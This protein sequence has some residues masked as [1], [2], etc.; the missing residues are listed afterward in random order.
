MIKSISKLIGATES[1]T[2]EW[3]PSLSQINEIIE[4]ITAFSNTDGGRVF[5]GVS[6]DGKIIGISIGKDTIENLTN[7]IAQHTEPKIHPHV[8]VTKIDSKE[9]IIINV[10]ESHDKLVLANGKPYI[11]V[12]KSTRQ[13]SKDDYENR[14][15][16]KHKD[17][18]QFDTQ[19]C[20]GAKLKD[21]DSNKV[22]WFMKKALEE[23]RLTIPEKV[24]TK[25]A[26]EYL[27][28]LHSGKPNN[29][30]ILL[31]GKDPQKFFVQAK[32]RAGRIKG[33]EGHDFLDMKVLEGTIPEI[34]ENALRFIAEYIKK[35]VFFDANQR[36]DKWEYPLRALEEALNNALAH[37]DYFSNADIQLAV[38]DDR[39]EIWNPGE[40]SKQ[41]TPEQLKVKHK[42]IPR[43]PFLADRLY[44]IKYIE[45]WGRGTNRIVDEM[46]QD[47]L[48]D[49]IF[50]NNSGGFE[51]TLMGPGK[52]FEKAIDDQKL[53]KLNLNDRQKK[54]MGFIKQRGEISRKQY[55]DLAGISVRQANRDLNDLIDKKVIASL[56]SGRSLKYKLRE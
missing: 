33:T 7:R 17:R 8:T 54:A 37:R 45:R 55:V 30:A 14:I 23:R 49:P 28:V 5:I 15:L 42:S 52:S 4:S 12:G 1:T 43:N 34:R 20:K 47:N 38:Y 19:V 21:I 36:Y 6:K 2:I 26:L 32:I 40:L 31:F 35:A 3:K 44:L 41:L 22:K 27:K 29:T 39:I 18:L 11:R 53:H 46:R 48:P 25:E 13:M 9:V 56:G 50:A 10:K 51:I 24:S 16:E